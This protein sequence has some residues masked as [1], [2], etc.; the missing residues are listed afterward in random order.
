MQVRLMEDLFGAELYEL[1]AEDDCLMFFGPAGRSIRIPF[2]ELRHLSVEGPGADRK[3][4]VLECTSG[5]YEGRFAGREDADALIHLLSEKCGCYMDIRM[6]MDPPGM[7]R[8]D[9]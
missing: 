2:T 6:D 5:I 4:F 3:R 7:P 9:F 8:T 1:F